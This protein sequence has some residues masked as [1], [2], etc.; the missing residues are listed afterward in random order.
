MVEDP[1]PKPPGTTQ[2]KRAAVGNGAEDSRQVLEESYSGQKRQLVSGVE[3]P[4]SG[5][6]AKRGPSTSRETRDRRERAN[7][8]NEWKVRLPH[9]L[10]LEESDGGQKRRLA[11][12]VEDLSPGEG[13]KRGPSTSRETRDRRERANE[14]NEW[15]V[16]LPHRLGT[17][18]ELHVECTWNSASLA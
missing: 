3:D 1:K 13:T 11:S 8:S 10:V 18:T 7:E 2:Q 14:S 12:G 17:R 15:K 4:S 5:S 6:G 9:R 16:R